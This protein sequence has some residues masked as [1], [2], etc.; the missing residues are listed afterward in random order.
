MKKIY[1]NSG[2]RNGGMPCLL[3]EGDGPHPATGGA[4]GHR[5][6]RV[7]LYETGSYD[8]YLDNPSYDYSILIGKNYTE[9]AATARF[10]VRDAADFGDEYTLL[11][12]GNWSLSSEAVEF[13]ETD[14]VHEVE[15]RLYGPY[16]P[17][18]VQEI[19]PRT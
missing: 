16:I 6:D 10:I 19:C 9:Q 2:C 18:P 3:L 5:Q 11:P 4:D 7:L 1:C 13:K 17:G 15:L 14:T 12:E 8:Y